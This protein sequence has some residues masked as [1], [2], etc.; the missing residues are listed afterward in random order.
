ML[1][2]TF[3]VV[4]F[5]LSVQYS[6]CHHYRGGS[7]SLRKINTSLAE[8]T[9]SFGWSLS[10]YF[11]DKE[12]ILE[13]KLIGPLND[14][15]YS[16]ESPITT[17]ETYCESYSIEDNWSFGRRKFFV[18]PSENSF[19]LTYEGCCWISTFGQHSNWQITMNA[20]I[21]QITYSSPVALMFPL[22]N[23]FIIRKF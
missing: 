6:T 9:I 5:I 8:V 23:F 11:C 3:F 20:S 18:E 17:V 4:A 16:G 1:N 15:L 22:S 19:S 14:Y 10:G 2:K 13:H 21:D 7:I 12:T